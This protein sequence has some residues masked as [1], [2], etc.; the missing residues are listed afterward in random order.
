LR[1]SLYIYRP[2]YSSL[3][4]FHSGGQSDVTKEIQSPTGVQN[5]WKALPQGAKVGIIAGSLGVLA[6]L[7]C[8]MAFCCFKQRRAGRKEHAA[9]LAAEQKEA[10]EMLTYKQQMQ[11]GKFGMGS[12]GFGKV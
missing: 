3:T 11:S 4:I 2:S 6:V 12:H 7:L 5:R 1:K 8:L 10:A 9:L